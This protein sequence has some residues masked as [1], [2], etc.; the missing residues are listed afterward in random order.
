MRGGDWPEDWEEGETDNQ[1]TVHPLYSST[2][3][4]FLLV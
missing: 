3:E 1:A 4:A 2:Q